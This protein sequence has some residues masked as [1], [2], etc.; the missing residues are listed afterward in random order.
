MKI[1]ADRKKIIITMLIRL[2]VLSIFWVGLLLSVVESKEAW[3][4]LVI[5]G[6]VFLAFAVSPL[7]HLNE[8]LE[9]YPDKIVFGKK[10]FTFSEPTEIK[11][12]REKTYFIGTRL[13]CYKD[14]GKMGFIAFLFSNA[15]EMDVTYIK[16]AHEEF[17]GFYVTIQS[18]ANL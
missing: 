16:R 2:M 12:V 17:I 14:R 10:E 13:R 18:H 5:M 1:G 3:I 4:R 8:V 9:L 11:W 15:Q 7:R 6:V